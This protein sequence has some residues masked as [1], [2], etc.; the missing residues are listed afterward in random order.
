MMK[1]R[2]IPGLFSF[3]NPTKEHG[4]I[5]PQSGGKGAFDSISPNPNSGG[6]LARQHQNLGNPPPQSN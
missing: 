1:A 2:E 5:Q 3:L 6:D 4:F